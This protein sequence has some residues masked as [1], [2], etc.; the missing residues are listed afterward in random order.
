LGLLDPVGDGIYNHF[1]VLSGTCLTKDSMVYTNCKPVPINEVKPGDTVFTINEQNGKL[2]THKVINVIN[3]GKKKV[4]DVWLNG[5]RVRATANH[6]FLRVE[7][8]RNPRV[9]MYAE[10]MKLT[11]DGWRQSDIVRRL[12]LPQST[13][14][15]W[16]S[17]KWKPRLERYT[18][19]WVPLE[20]LKPGDLIVTVRKL[21][22]QRRSGKSS[23]FCEFIGFMIGDGWISPNRG[24]FAICFAKSNNTEINERYVRLAQRLFGLKMREYKQGW[25]Y[26]YSK[27]IGEKLRNLGLDK[28]ANEKIVPD[29]IYEEPIENKIAFLQGYF[30]ADATFYKNPNCTTEKITVESP[31]ER[32]VRGLHE[33]CIISGLRVSNVRWRERETRA[34][35]QKKFGKRKFWSFTVAEK[36]LGAGNWKMR[37]PQYLLDD[38]YF[39]VERIQKIEEA[40]EEEVFDL[41][42]EG[43]HNFIANG[44]VVH[45]S[46]A[47]PHIAGLLACA[48]QYYDSLGVTLTVDLVKTICETYGEPKNNDSGWG[49]LTWDMFKRYAAEHII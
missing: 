8:E 10:V 31:N 32:L 35:H 27:E 11:R 13:T 18:L 49:L 33:L 7:R 20:S 38:E 28:K 1:A 45:N 47:T 12:G 15:H 25:Y 43:C 6:P 46:M 22:S 23:E 17:G 5:K 21:P 30:N 9:S 39:A 4:F 16:Q 29:W 36:K 14:E 40:G 19:K 41:T 37:I 44:V 26:C 2:E 34:P 42:I 48:K 3:N 24:S